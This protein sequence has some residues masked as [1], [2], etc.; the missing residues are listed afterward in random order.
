MVSSM[1]VG[2][3]G[4]HHAAGGRRCSRQLLRM[5]ITCVAVAAV[6]V[7]PSA[8]RATIGQVA[9]GGRTE[10]PMLKAGRA[11]HKYRVK[12]NSW[13][14]VSAAA[15]GGAVAG[16]AVRGQAA[17]G[18]RAGSSNIQAGACM[19]MGACKRQGQGGGLL[20]GCLS[21]WQ[22]CPG[23]RYTMA[24]FEWRRGPS[25][26][27]FAQWKSL[28]LSSR[29]PHVWCDVSSTVCITL[30][31]TI[32]TSSMGSGSI[33]RLHCL[34]LTAASKQ[35]GVCRMAGGGDVLSNH[36]RLRGIAAWFTGGL[37]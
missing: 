18:Q 12:R 7:V 8:C 21:L 30:W 3:P 2:D 11:Y 1:T 4:A 19:I 22:H 17:W 16:W 20:E 14:K 35:H 32:S 27:L 13:P 33:H 34:L 26:S 24:S 29:A 37:S 9:G 5:A 6:Q 28:T 25:G 15:S 10:K 36:V 23:R 31:G